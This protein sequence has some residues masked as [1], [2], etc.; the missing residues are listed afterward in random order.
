MGKEYF[1]QPAPAPGISR[2]H[3]RSSTTTITPT[4]EPFGS[5]V[6]DVA[7]SKLSAPKRTDL[8]A[9]SPREEH[10]SRFPFSPHPNNAKKYPWSPPPPRWLLR[11]GQFWLEKN[12]IVQGEKKQR[13]REKGGQEHVG[14]C[15]A[16]L[17]QVSAQ[18][19]AIFCLFLFLAAAS[20]WQ[21][22]QLSSS[23]SRSMGILR[24]FSA[25]SSHPDFLL[26]RPPQA[27]SQGG[28]KTS[29]GANMAVLHELH[30]RN[31]QQVPPPP[32]PRAAPTSPREA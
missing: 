10:P 5:S 24:V 6:G 8:A 11:E 25:S 7:A 30:P 22:H 28:G 13:E 16:G 1:H 21:P 31:H 14:G 15:Q 19:R 20:P 12:R 4:L 29:K 32:P 27:P 26:R 9:S 17:L 23:A 18:H 3:P 2:Y